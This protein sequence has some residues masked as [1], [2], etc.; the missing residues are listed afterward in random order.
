MEFTPT[1]L[2]IALDHLAKSR[3]ANVV[4]S[5]D[6]IFGV[7]ERPEISQ[8]LRSEMETM[9]TEERRAAMPKSVWGITH[10]DTAKL[11]V[12]PT[13]TEIESAVAAPVPTEVTNYQ[14]KQALNATPADRETVEALISEADQNTK[15]GWNHASTIKRSNPLF[16]AAVEQLGWSKEKIDGLFILGA[17]FHL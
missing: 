4:P 14:V 13:I 15:D 16:I 12:E 3:D 7:T 17:T 1:Q 6:Y 10:W 9:T 2:A 8:E 5:V 11:G